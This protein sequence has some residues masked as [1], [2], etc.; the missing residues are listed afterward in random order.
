MP[1]AHEYVQLPKQAHG[2]L[3]MQANYWKAWIGRAI[4]RSQWREDRLRRVN[5]QLK[6]QA[7]QREAALRSE[8]DLAQ[9]AGVMGTIIN[10]GNMGQGIDSS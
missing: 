10:M 2:E 5:R 8:L 3:V 6:E 1:W 4:G 9:R 7:A